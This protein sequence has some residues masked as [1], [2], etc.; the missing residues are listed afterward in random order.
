M[1]IESLQKFYFVQKTIIGRSEQYIATYLDRARGRL[2]DTILLQLTNAFFS[3]I[4]SDNYLSSRI[5]CTLR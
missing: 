2:Q 3:V 5:D 1:S 4:S